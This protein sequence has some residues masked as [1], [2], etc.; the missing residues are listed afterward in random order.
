MEHQYSPSA[1]KMKSDCD[2]LPRG[3]VQS[4]A[5]LTLQ[6]NSVADGRGDI[7]QFE[8]ARKGMVGLGQAVPQPGEDYAAK[9]SASYD[10]VAQSFPTREDA[11]KA[12]E[13]RAAEVHW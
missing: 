11:V 13:S 6:I 2:R 4:R 5:E 9:C 8:I 1:M 7:N 10:L 3:T 12:A